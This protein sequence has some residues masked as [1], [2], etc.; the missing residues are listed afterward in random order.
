MMG[1]ART[2]QRVSGNNLKN[3]LPGVGG[4][5]GFKATASEAVPQ[6]DKTGEPFAKFASRWDLLPGRVASLKRGRP[7]R[8]RPLQGRG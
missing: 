1:P 4:Q 2:S 3:R 6:T 7:A 5:S 8:T